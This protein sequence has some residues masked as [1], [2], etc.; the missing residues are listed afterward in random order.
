MEVTLHAKS[1]EN[2]WLWLQ[3]AVLNLQNS[4]NSKSNKLIWISD[5]VRVLCGD[6]GDLWHKV[7]CTLQPKPRLHTKKNKTKNHSIPKSFIVRHDYARL[8]WEMAPTLNHYISIPSQRSHSII[9]IKCEE[10]SQCELMVK[11][12]MR[13]LDCSLNEWRSVLN[14]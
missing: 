2:I 11:R 13:R 7:Q 14:E 9:V 8:R 12:E 5:L 10:A 4:L 1:T 3:A 6:T